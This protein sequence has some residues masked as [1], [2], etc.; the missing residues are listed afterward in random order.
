MDDLLTLTELWVADRICELLYDLLLAS[1]LVDESEGEEGTSI[2]KYVC[3][4]LRS[5]HI[6]TEDLIALLVV[7]TVDHAK[8]SSGREPLPVIALGCPF[9][10]FMFILKYLCY[11]S[12]TRHPVFQS[13]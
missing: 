1:G 11:S 12:R 3:G 10:I 5:R 9:C 7:I 13:A 4:A 8:S 6:W 2:L